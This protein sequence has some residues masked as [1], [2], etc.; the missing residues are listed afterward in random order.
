[1]RP[2]PRWRDPAWWLL[3]L[4]FPFWLALRIA[5]RLTTKDAS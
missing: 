2:T 3:A 4:Y 1:M 5:A